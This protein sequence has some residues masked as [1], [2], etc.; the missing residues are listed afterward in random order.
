MQS[1][2]FKRICTERVA[3]LNEAIASFQQ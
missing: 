2:S 3:L 1:D